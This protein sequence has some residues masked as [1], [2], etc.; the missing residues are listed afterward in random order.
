[1]FRNFGV[2][3][4]LQKDKQAN[5]GQHEELAN[6]FTPGLDELHF[7]VTISMGIEGPKTFSK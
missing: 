1:M 3:S 2:Y 5:V 7:P 4:C 6:T